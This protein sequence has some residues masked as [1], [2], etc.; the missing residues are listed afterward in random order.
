MGFDNEID[1]VFADGPLEGEVGRA[2]DTSGVHTQDGHRYENTYKPDEFGRPIFVYRPN[3]D[4]EIGVTDEIEVEP[5]I[6]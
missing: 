1:I 3:V 5:S 4:V 6:E 2:K